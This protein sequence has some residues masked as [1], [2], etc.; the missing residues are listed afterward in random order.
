MAQTCTIKDFIE[1]NFMI[2]NW[3]ESMSLPC[4]YNCSPNRDNFKMCH[5]FIDLPKNG[6]L[7]Y[8]F[9]QRYDL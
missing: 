7:T 1:N 8:S 4:F 6:D 9:F 2:Q 3:E 5:V